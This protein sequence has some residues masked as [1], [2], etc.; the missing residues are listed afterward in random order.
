[1]I[2]SLSVEILQEIGVM[3]FKLADQ[4]SLRSVCR[5][6][7]LAINPL[8]FSTVVL[9]I[10]SRRLDESLSY[11]EALANGKTGW[12]Q[13]A[14]SLKITRLSPGGGF[15]KKEDFPQL[16][17]AHRRMEQSLRSALESLK[18][19]RI[20]TRSLF[21]NDLHLWI[22]R[23]DLHGLERLSGLSKLK[24]FTTNTDGHDGPLFIS[25]QPV[26]K[27]IS[28]SPN[29]SSLDL[30]VGFMDISDIW[31]MLNAQKIHLKDLT[32]HSVT[33][34]LIQYL[35][36]YSGLERL[37]LPDAGS[38]IGVE[39]RDTLADL[40]FQRALPRHAETLVAFSLPDAY[41]GHWSFGLHNVDVISRLRKLRILETSVTM[42][43]IMENSDSGTK[44]AVVLLLEL[45]ANRR[46]L[47]NVAI[48][49][50]TAER[51]RG[52]T[53][54]QPWMHHSTTVAKRMRAIVHEFRTEIPSQT[55]LRVWY[56]WYKLKPTSDSDSEQTL[57]S[58]QEFAHTD[59]KWER[60]KR[61]TQPFD[62]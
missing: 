56:N 4:K 54:G 22:M 31:K 52:A 13:Y 29:L 35:A 23:S 48:L 6:L 3:L 32:T 10:H 59:R 50:A 26:V 20:V 24:L 42:A 45:V 16:Q 25:F 44:N 37:T 46:A 27:M 14:Q 51:N 41:E 60:L 9:D 39:E 15:M 40:F 21:L 47:Q 36:S 34:E 53:C 7:G 58:Y 8:F 18:N 11:L 38:N 33:I 17:S 43:D 61:L 62:V 49:P 2:L 28:Q 5:V 57:W 30:M 19:V 55:L 1:M 12:S